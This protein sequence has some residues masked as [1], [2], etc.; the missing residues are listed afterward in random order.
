TGYTWRNGAWKPNTETLPHRGTSA[1]GGYSTVQDLVNFASALRAH[2]LL[3]PQDTQLLTTEK[4]EMP[5]EGAKYAYGFE[6]TIADGVR[7]YGHG[8]G[9]PGV[10]GGLRIYPESGYVLVVLSN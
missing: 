5:M 6:E 7:Y 2:K 1:G 9:A 3:T 4:V 10:S 8:G